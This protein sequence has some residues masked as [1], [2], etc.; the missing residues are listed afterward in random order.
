MKKE[1]LEEEKMSRDIVFTNLYD[2][3]QSDYVTRRK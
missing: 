3:Q 2:Q 1:T